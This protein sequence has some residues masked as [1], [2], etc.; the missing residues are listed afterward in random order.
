MIHHNLNH[1]TRYAIASSH[2]KV[3]PGAVVVVVPPPPPPLDDSF[4]CVMARRNN[5]I[6]FTGTE[7]RC[8][9][10]LTPVV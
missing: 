2:T 6:S 9:Y 5:A 1:S 3:C 10:P 8:T 7:P 4:I